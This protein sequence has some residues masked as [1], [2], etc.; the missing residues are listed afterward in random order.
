MHDR[1]LLMS[2]LAVAGFL[3]LAAVVSNALIEHI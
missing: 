2:I 1:I 3:A